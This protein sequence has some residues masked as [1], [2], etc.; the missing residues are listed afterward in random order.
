[1]GGGLLTS[2]AIIG[3]A[4][5]LGLGITLASG[6]HLVTDLLGSGAFAVSAVASKILGGGGGQRA[7]VSTVI[8]TLWSIRLAGEW[9]DLD[10]CAGW[11]CSN[12]FTSIQV[13]PH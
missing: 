6:T 1:M 10:F 5:L 2:G 11:R 8:I 9:Q 13:W 12:T 3:S 7:L 4:N